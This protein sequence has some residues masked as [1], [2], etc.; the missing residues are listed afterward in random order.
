MSASRIFLLSPANSGGQRAKLLYRD[1]A[2]FELA[3]QLRTPKGAE[4]GDIFAF[5]SGLYF[6]GK[7]DYA[8]AF[9]SPPRGVCGALTITTNR[10]LLPAE[11]EVTIDELRAMG[12]VPIDVDDARYRGPL[13]ASARAIAAKLKSDCQVV[14][15]GSVATGKYVDILLDV[16]GDRLHFPS[17]F[18]GRGDMSRG[19]LML[20][21]V[22]E[23]REL[24][25]APV[26]GAIHHGVRPPKLQQRGPVA[27]SRPR[28]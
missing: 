22:E 5:L 23:A 27:V 9:A 8:R 4:I 17:E 26:R 13:E 6:R 10:G 21:C 24:T 25:Y 11:T 16:F 20:R 19:G 18:V 28:P 15:L 2:R 7:L 3:M 14:L 1:A 12:S